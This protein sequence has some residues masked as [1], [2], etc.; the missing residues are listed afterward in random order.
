MC[1]RC[2]HARGCGEL[3]VYVV[4]ERAGGGSWLR[5]LRGDVL[6]RFSHLRQPRGPLE[7]VSVTSPR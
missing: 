1:T 2:G 5:L 3:C 4:C 7:E 6:P